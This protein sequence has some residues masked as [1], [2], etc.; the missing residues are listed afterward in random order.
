MDFDTFEALTFDCYGTLIDWESGILAAIEPLL[1][2]HGVKQSAAEALELYAV[3]EGEAE[4]GPYRPYREVL[5]RVVQGMGERLGFVPDPGELDC[6]AGS[7]PR[8]EPFPDSVPALKALEKRFRL[9]ILS[10][11]DDDLFGFTAAKLGV[12]FDW[13]ITAEQV[14]SYKPD[15]RNFVAAIERIGLPKKRILHV[16]QS[17][18]HDVVPATGLGMTSVW[19]DRR[20]ERPGSGATPPVDG[21]PALKVRSLAELVE[22]IEM[23]EPVGPVEPVEPVGPVEP[24]EPS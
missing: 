2:R 18:Y 5:R 4:S 6:L 10:N 15:P 8:W 7:L 14:G 11:V 21:R 9:G 17:L 24:I 3:L 13:V 23:I 16:A 22:M 12:D 1:V 19:V 20:G